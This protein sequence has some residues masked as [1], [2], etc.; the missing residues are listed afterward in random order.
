MPHQTRPPSGH[1]PSRPGHLHRG[2]AALQTGRR[3]RYSVY[4]VHTVARDG[5]TAEAATSSDSY[6][7]V[8]SYACPVS[9]ATSTGLAALHN[10][11][12]Y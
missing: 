7:A 3:H 9:A 6:S 8:W 11:G 10:T 2:P 5:W 1:L 4:V 12:Y